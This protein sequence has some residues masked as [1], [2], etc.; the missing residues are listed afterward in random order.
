MQAPPTKRALAFDAHSRLTGRY[1]DDLPKEIDALGFSGIQM[2]SP[3]FL[4]KVTETGIFS[5][6]DCY[7]RLA[8]E[9]GLI[10]VFPCD[11]AYWT[12]IGDARKLKAAR[13]HAKTRSAS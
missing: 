1:S 5:L 11:G 4:P 3:A 2:I 10:R 6:T 8:G 7:V 13:R 12:D 9:G